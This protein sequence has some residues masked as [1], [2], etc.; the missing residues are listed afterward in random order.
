MIIIV[1]MK[2]IIIIITLIMILGKIHIYIVDSC[3]DIGDYY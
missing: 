3:V 2:M 1:M